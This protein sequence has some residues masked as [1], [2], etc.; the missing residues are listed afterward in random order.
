MPVPQLVR[1]DSTGLPCLSPLSG[2]E[3]LSVPRGTGSAGWYP[4]HF[5]WFTLMVP[6]RLSAG[7]WV[8]DLPYTT[9]HSDDSHAA[10]ACSAL[11]F[12]PGY[13]SDHCPTNV[14]KFG[15]A[16]WAK[17]S[18]HSQTQVQLFS[19]TFGLFLISPGRRYTS[20]EAYNRRVS[21]N[22]VLIKQ[23]PVLPLSFSLLLLIE[24]GK[25]GQ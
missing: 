23:H 4:D 11:L 17:E 18:L 9:I 21:R 2:G 12:M 8:T 16:F 14:T 6:G 7:I 22:K 13:I 5:S 1:V 25:N 20:V 19:S 15:F 24:I 3:A 10:V